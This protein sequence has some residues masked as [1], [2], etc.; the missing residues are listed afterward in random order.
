MVLGGST[1]NDGVPRLIG[2]LFSEQ[3]TNP[4]RTS[5]ETSILHCRQRCRVPHVRISANGTE[6]SR[7]FHA[8]ASSVEID[9]FGNALPIVSR[10]RG[11]LDEFV[12]KC[13]HSERIF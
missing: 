13:R 4:V 12:E 11:W 10:A 3:N 8:S 1:V 9:G 7:L 6:A 5:L 2:D